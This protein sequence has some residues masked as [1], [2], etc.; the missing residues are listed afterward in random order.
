[1]KAGYPLIA[2]LPLVAPNQGD[3][4]L[5]FSGTDFPWNSFLLQ[6]ERLPF[7]LWMMT[8]T[9]S[10]AIRESCE[11]T[12][13][14]LI[15]LKGLGRNGNPEQPSEDELMSAELDSTPLGHG[16]QKSRERLFINYGYS[17][18]KQLSTAV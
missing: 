12:L 5:S 13:G 10:F 7:P 3:D 8:P 2:T 17:R 16:A 4:S 14:K 1:M 15:E 11:T 18:T 9:I 6:P